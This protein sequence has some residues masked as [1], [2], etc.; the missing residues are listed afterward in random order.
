M[1]KNPL[2]PDVEL[3]VRGTGNL[4]DVTY[5]PDELAQALLQAEQAIQRVCREARRWLVPSP[6]LDSTLNRLLLAQLELLRVHNYRNVCLL[7][8]AASPLPLAL[9]KPRRARQRKAA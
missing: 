3:V 9:A 5:Y 2:A 6:Q 7:P 4:R 8:G 1:A